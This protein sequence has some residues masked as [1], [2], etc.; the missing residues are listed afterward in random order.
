MNK[1]HMTGR[2]YSLMMPGLSQ[3][4][5][6]NVYYMFEKRKLK[7]SQTQVEKEKTKSEKSV[8]NKLGGANNNFL[9]KS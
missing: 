4:D 2:N 5:I 1:Y 8:S 9:N 7:N 3:Q 6:H